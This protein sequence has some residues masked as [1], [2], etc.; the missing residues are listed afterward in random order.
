MLI[1]SRLKEPD[2]T[3]IILAAHE[4][5]AL[6]SELDDGEL[7]LDTA[8]AVSCM[9]LLSDS[10][11]SPL[12]NPARPRE[13]LRSRVRQIRSGSGPPAPDR[14]RTSSRRARAHR[15]SGVGRHEPGPEKRGS[16]SARR[17]TAAH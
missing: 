6:A 4:L 3:R 14:P 8:C 7:A 17:S 15:G 2:E 16:R 9:R 1:R 13:E 10:A 5:E 12:L 11:G